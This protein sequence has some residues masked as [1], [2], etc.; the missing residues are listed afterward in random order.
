MLINSTKSFDE[1]GL[2]EFVTDFHRE[3]LLV[4]P[5]FALALTHLGRPLPPA[6]A[7][8]T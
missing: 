3:R 1:L 6:R 8:S 4:V 7:C 5:A 2:D